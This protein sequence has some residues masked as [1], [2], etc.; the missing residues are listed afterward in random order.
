MVVNMCF[1]VNSAIHRGKHKIGN[2]YVAW[3]HIHAKQVVFSC[4][5]LSLSF[6][7]DENE[8][9]WLAAIKYF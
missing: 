9:F 7:S 4:V 8:Y 6:V 2:G 3:D 1:V 5:F